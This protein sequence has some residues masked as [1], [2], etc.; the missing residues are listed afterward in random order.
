[1]ISAFFQILNIGTDDGLY[2]WVGVGVSNAPTNDFTAISMNGEVEYPLPRFPLNIVGAA[3]TLW[4]Q[5]PLLC[6]GLYED[7]IIDSCYFLPD[8]HD[9]NL[10]LEIQIH[11]ISLLL[12]PNHIL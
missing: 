3:Y 2:I 1:M 11:Q 12:I 4:G 9:S 7:K 5:S 10:V 8:R 6:G